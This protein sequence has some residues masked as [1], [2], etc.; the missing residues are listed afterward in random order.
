M[1][2]P[3]AWP[4][5]IAGRVRPVVRTPAPLLSRAGTA[6]DPADDAVLRLAADLVATMRASPGCVGLAAPQ[7]GVPAR[8]FCVDVDLLA[9]RLE[10]VGRELGIDIGRRPAEAD[11][12]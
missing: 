9:E 12:L 8:V 7:I 11:L 3:I 1:S 4:A 5:E 10:S 2:S 6:V